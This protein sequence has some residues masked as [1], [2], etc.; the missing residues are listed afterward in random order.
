MFMKIFYYR[1]KT[2]FQYI[3]FF[4]EAI[5]NLRNVPKHFFK[6]NRFVF[7]SHHKYVHEDKLLFKKIKLFQ[8]FYLEFMKY[9]NTICLEK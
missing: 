8:R 5:L 6:K 1:D 4:A 9:T 3:I 2:F 7:D